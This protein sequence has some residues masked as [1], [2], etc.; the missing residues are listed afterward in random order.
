MYSRTKLSAHLNICYKCTDSRLDARGNVR[1]C[2]VFSGGIM[3]A[4]H[5]GNNQKQKFIAVLDKHKSVDNDRYFS[6]TPCWNWNGN[7]LPKGYGYTGSFFG[8]KIYVHR[9][10]YLIFIGDLPHDR[11][12]QIDH[13]CK[14]RS[15]F[16]PAHL[17]LVT[18]AENN[19]RITD[20]CVR[21]HSLL[22]ESNIFR[23]G[24]K[25][26]CRAC[27]N[28]FNRDRYDRLYS[29]AANGGHCIYTVE[30]RASAALK[31]AS[32]S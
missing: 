20:T 16:N 31:R 11:K 28:I 7:K 19:R 26:I 1:R 12:M 8:N 24:G 27:R 3:S 21:G 4:L 22:D 30:Q 5:L 10:S 32:P 14:N 15:C 17:E 18:A 29:K 13:L 9:L 2:C 25:R 6:G 23:K